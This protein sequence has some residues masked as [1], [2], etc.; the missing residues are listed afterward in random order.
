[1]LEEKEKETQFL[2]KQVAQLQK[3]IGEKDAQI[4][5]V[6][7]KSRNLQVSLAYTAKQILAYIRRFCLRDYSF[8]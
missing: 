3:L 1:M 7:L 8:T 5:D 2:Q 6:K 4:K